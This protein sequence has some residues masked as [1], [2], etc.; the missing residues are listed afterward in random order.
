MSKRDPLLLAKE[1]KYVSKRDLVHK[2]KETQY[3]SKRD[4][5]LLAHTTQFSVDL[6]RWVQG[7]GF[8]V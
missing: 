5:L 1:T 7:L 2:A 3:M 6:G 4:R 8:R